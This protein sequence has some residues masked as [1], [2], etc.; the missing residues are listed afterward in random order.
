VVVEDVNKLPLFTPVWVEPPVVG[1]VPHL[2]GLTAFRQA[3]PPVAATVWG[4]ELAMPRAYRDVPFLV[5]SD[6]TAA[7]L[8]RRG[9]DRSRIH[10]SPPGIDH[11]F[12]RPAAHPERFAE[13]TLVYVGRLRR[14]KGL[15]GPIRALSLLAERGRS[16]PLLLVAGRGSDQ[17]RLEAL[18][19]ELGLRD[20]VRFLGYVTEEE[21]R[22]LL[23]RAWANVYP[24]PKEGW[25]ITNVE[26]AACGTPS[27]AS[28]APGL[29]ESVRD[30]ETG[31][32]VPHHDVDSWAGRMDRLCADG[33]L[34]ARLGRGAIAHAAHFTWERAADDVEALLATVVPSEQ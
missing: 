4:A 14:Y 12:F 6:S 10:V 1:L 27:I 16:V 7:D 32:L 5:I 31:F 15:D 34:R 2:F 8:E 18:V 20:H 3:I 28:D 9:F 21:K 33:A 19:Q 17:P 11:G 29:R 22:E 13:P 30:G 23:R 24:S 25:G 26:A